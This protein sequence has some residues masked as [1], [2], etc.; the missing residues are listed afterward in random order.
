MRYNA[1]KSDE[2]LA[3]VSEEH[4]SSIFGRLAIST[5][6]YKTT[7]SAIPETGHN[8]PVQNSNF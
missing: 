2:S 6:I 7:T 8:S 3:D 1:E 5:Q 4:Y